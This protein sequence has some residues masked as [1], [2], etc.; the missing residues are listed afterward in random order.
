[1]IMRHI[2]DVYHI[3]MRGHPER[4][5][6]ISVG[7]FLNIEAESVVFF[8]IMKKEKRKYSSMVINLLFYLQKLSIFEIYFNLIQILKILILNNVLGMLHQY[9]IS[10]RTFELQ[11]VKNPIKTIFQLFHISQH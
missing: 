4:S 2:S 10:N 6:Y 1:M 11:S 3:R 8:K 9:S 5:K 7:I